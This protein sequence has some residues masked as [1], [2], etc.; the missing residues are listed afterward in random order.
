MADIADFANDL[1]QERI[2]QAVAARLALM[3][4]QPQ[5]SLMFCDDC[6]EAI[7]E[8]RRLAQPGCT[9]CVGCKAADDLRAS[10]Y[11]R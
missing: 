4:S 10:R 11:A 9:L 8:A 1:V 5:H 6:D 7:P 3:S 2:D